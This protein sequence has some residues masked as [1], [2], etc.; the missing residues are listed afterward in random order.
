MDVRVRDKWRCAGQKNGLWQMPRAQRIRP[1]FLSIV[2]EVGDGLADGAFINHRFLVNQSGHER[3]RA[4]LVDPP[5]DS[6]R[7]FEDALQRIVGEERSGRVARDA[8]LMLDVAQRFLEVQSRE[9][10]T[11]R[12][13]L[14]KGLIDRE[15][16]HA[17]EIGMAYQDQRRERLAVHLIAEQQPQLVEHRLGQ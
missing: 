1:A 17:A 9:M 5:R 13:P 8:Q 4:N 6:F 11:H 10:A 12:E 2:V 3:G 7:V 15:V 14:L 16:E